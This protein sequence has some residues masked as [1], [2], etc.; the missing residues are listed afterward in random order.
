MQAMVRVRVFEGHT[1]R[2]TD[3]VVSEDCRWLLSASMDGT[4]RVWDIPASATLQ[5]SR[6]P[7]D[8]P[9]IPPSPPLPLR[10]WG[11]PSSGP[12]GVP[13]VFEEPEA[14]RTGC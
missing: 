6:H 5:V 10:F 8:T 3:L 4:L 1:D 14:V 7:P 13:K 2:V 12:K 9:S 11:V